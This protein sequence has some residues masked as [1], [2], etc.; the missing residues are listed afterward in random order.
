MLFQN[1]DVFILEM[2]Y[3]YNIYLFIFP[4]EYIVGVYWNYLCFLWMTLFCL[5]MLKRVIHFIFF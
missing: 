3:F 2:N 4:I 5:C 1:F